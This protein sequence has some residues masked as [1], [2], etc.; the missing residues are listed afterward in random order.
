VASAAADLLNAQGATAVY[1][2]IKTSGYTLAQAEK[3]FGSPAG[4]LEEEARKMGLPVFHEGTSFVPKT[5]FALLEKGEAVIPAAYNPM[6]N[7]GYT[8]G[9]QAEL[10]AEMRLLREQ[11]ARL[12]EQLEA[13]K[14]HTGQFSDQFDRVSANGNNLSVEFLTPQKVEVAA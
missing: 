5:G 14:T 1:N 10:L 12:E 6:A 7:P 13:I 2:A 3:I 8:G 9:N 4:S 11:N